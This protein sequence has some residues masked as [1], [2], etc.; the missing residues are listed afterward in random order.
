M[1]RLLYPIYGLLSSGAESILLVFVQI[2]RFVT[3]Q[4]E[5]GYDKM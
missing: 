1:T 4:R 3:L 5:V 2:R